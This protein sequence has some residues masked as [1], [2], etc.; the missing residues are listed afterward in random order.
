MDF[1]PEANGIPR[2][3][4]VGEIRQIGLNVHSEVEPGGLF[5]TAS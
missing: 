1:R 4:T 2:H 5:Q 3:R